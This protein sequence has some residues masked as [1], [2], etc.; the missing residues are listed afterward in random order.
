MCVCVRPD[1]DAASQQREFDVGC[2]DLETR[3]SAGWKVDDLWAAAKKDPFPPPAAAPGSS[4]AAAVAAA[5]AAPVAPPRG[6]LFLSSHCA[7]S[8]D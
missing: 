1:R 7:M 2:A 6:A 3:L 8:Q 4:P 5:V